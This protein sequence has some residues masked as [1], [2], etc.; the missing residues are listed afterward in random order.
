MFKR[1]LELRGFVKFLNEVICIRV[2]FVGNRVKGVFLRGIIRYG[3]CGREKV[4]FRVNCSFFFRKSVR[5][6][7]F[8]SIGVNVECWVILWWGRFYFGGYSCF[9]GFF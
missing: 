2:E 6:F 9:W 3:G 4:V 1:F 7:F 5:K 8:F